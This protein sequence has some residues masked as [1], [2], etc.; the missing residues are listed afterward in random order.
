MKALITGGAGFIGS[1]LA[2]ALCR[3]GAKVIVVDDLSLG[4]IENLKW[5]RAS[6]QLD[7]VEG[8][9]SD[10]TLMKQLIADC[11][12]MFHE[13]AMPSVPVSVAEPVK[14]NTQNLDATLRLLVLARDSGVKRFLFASSSAIYG[15]NDAAAKNERLP[16]QP[17][18]PYALQKYTAERYGQLFHQLYG[19]PA[20]SLRYFNVFGPRQ[21]FDSPY[22]GVIA[23]FCTGML[24]G[25]APVI[26][27]DG[28]QSRDFTYIEN[29][30]QANLLAAEAPNAAGKVFNIAGG[31]SI[32]LLQLVEELNRLTGQS[33]KP[34]F[35]QARAGDV[36]SS[37]ADISAAEREL[38]YRCKISW[39]E[40]LQRTLE[41]YRASCH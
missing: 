10:E 34:R 33:L 18:S 37:L 31:Q 13:A 16:P 1:H 23:K 21:A 6:D 29:V 27:G 12:W 8:D 19:L 4:K 11:D 38:G 40:G 25:K 26:Y 9:V 14:T 32:S 41:F 36:R 39:Q 2:E 35:E 24:A 3:R 15:D 22:S 5:K 28:L 30:V 20:V 7:F 17:L